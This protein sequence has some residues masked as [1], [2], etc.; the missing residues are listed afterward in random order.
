MCWN[1]ETYYQKSKIILPK[2]ASGVRG[3]SPPPGMLHLPPPP[4][5][6]R[7]RL[8]TA[9][10]SPF[11]TPQC[12]IKKYGH[13]ILEEV[14]GFTP[15]LAKE[16]T[17]W[18][19]T[20]VTVPCPHLGELRDCILPGS[21]GSLSLPPSFWDANISTGWLPPRGCRESKNVVQDETYVELG[22]F[23]LQTL[24]VSNT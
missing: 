4:L 1:Y 13:G 9:K 3:P 21:P 8:V 12:H 18:D 7:G 24:Q 19:S 16:G 11:S 22:D 5:L 10:I 20:P 15:Q 23:W 2:A 14:E 6:M 17:Q